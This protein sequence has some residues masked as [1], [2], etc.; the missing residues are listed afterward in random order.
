MVHVTSLSYYLYSN[1]ETL[2]YYYVGFIVLPFHGI[3][4]IN[5]QSFDPIFSRTPFPGTPSWPCPAFL[6]LSHQWSFL[7]IE[8]GLLS[9]VYI[10]LR[11][12]RGREGK[13]KGRAMSLHVCM[14]FSCTHFPMCSHLHA[15]FLI[16]FHTAE[17]KSGGGAIYGPKRSTQGW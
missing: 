3:L 13:P 6:S 4:K 7:S 14:R 15:T 5:L 17:R 9:Y 16:T 2:I 12:R 10:L 1:I 8:D 11:R